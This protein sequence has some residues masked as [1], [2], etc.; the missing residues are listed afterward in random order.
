MDSAILVFSCFEGWSMLDTN[1]TSVSA[2]HN[3]HHTGWAFRTSPISWTRYFTNESTNFAT[4][5]Y[6]WSTGQGMRVRVP[7]SKWEKTCLGPICTIMP[8]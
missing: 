2:R 6:K 1:Q 4:N 8:L 7:P 3:T 5:Q